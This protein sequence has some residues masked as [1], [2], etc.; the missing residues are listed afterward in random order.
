[1]I[2]FT[3]P[4]FYNNYQLNNYFIML[5]NKNKNYFKKDITFLSVAGNFPYN[6]WQGGFNEFNNI[7]ASYEEFNSFLN[8]SL[9]PIKFNCANICLTEEDLDDTKMNL[10]LSVNQTGINS[11]S[12]SNLSIYNYLKE[13]YPYYNYIFSREANLINEFSSDVINILNEQNLFSFIEIPENLSTNLEFLKEI[14]KKDKVELLI[15]NK[16][17]FN[18]NYF[19][20]CKINEHMNQYNFSNRM[21][22]TK[23]PIRNN[24]ELNITLEDIKNIYYPLGFKYFS[25]DNYLFGVENNLLDVYINFFI[26]DEY[27]YQVY[28]NFIEN[29]GFN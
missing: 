2:Y 26:K 3:L 12:I 19:S 1:M 24:I 8:N 5:N 14:E 20:E 9:I 6:Y 10:I 28:K 17:C 21:L 25:F 18:C 27:K 4:N 23:C 22:M 13:K 7:N 29:R 15:G 16:K 11:I